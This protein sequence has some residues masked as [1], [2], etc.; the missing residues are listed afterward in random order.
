VALTA[1]ETFGTVIPGFVTDLDGNLAVTTDTTDTGYGIVPGFMTDS[2]GRLLVS[3]DSTGAEWD[4]GFLRNED[5]ALIITTA[6]LVSPVI[7]AK[8]P[9][10]TTDSSGYL[11][12]GVNS[13]GTFYNGFVRN[14]DLSLAIIESAYEVNVESLSPTLLLSLS[15]DRG[16][17]NL[18]SNPATATGAGSV[19]IGAYMPGPITDIDTGATDFD[20]S[21]DLIATTYST[22]RNRVVNPSLETNATSW[23]ANA[24]GAT[25][26]RVTTEFYDGTASLEVVHDGVATDRGAQTDLI[27]GNV[28]IAHTA[29]IYVKAPVGAAL[30]LRLA[31]IQ[32]DGT[33]VVGN[34]D[35]AYTG[36]GS[37]DRVSVTRTFGALGVN[38][39][40]IVLNTVAEARTWYLD[41]ALLEQGSTLGTFFPTA[42]QLAS[43]EAGWTGTAHASV[44]NIGVF[45]N[46]TARTF[47][48]WAYRDNSAG[49][50]CL[51]GSSQA[52]QNVMMRLESGNQNVT[53]NTNS[54]SATA[55]T[56]TN[57]WPGNGQWVHWAFVFDE[58]GASN[59][60]SLYINGALVS[61]VTETDQY[62]YGTLATTAPVLQIGMRAPTSDPFDGKI[63]WVSVHQRVLTAAE[64]LAAYE[65]R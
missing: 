15:A 61:T 55:T 56:W 52:G 21:N 19:T 29:S 64:I 5:G 43:G 24:S 13:S 37:W 18:G 8:V 25:V 63:A 57:A 50:D 30:I 28:S 32:V 48:G 12:V 44:A 27:A 41:A 46:G 14:S 11:A 10:F 40:V 35:Q 42:A 62:G 9:G 2:D 4:G 17:T 39:R 60:L 23:S 54:T 38:A 49:G 47:M 59:N 58:A 65:A 20:G 51:I 7:G 22:R 3:L 34:T 6:A 1:S 16:L 53:F 36:T 31:E 33:T 45:A 26:A